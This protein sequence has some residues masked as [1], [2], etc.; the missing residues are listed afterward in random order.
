MIQ[1]Q[2]GRK[3]SVE[4]F[5]DVLNRSTLGERRPVN[6]RERMEQMLTA[7]QILV[8]AW[9]GEV[10]I[11]VSRALSDFS[12]CTYLADLAVDERYQH[13]GI[14]RTLLELTHEVAGL[15]TSLILLAAPKAVDYYPKIGM[16]RSEVCFLK[17]RIH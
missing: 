2:T 17:D 4:E 7:A 15:Q 3:L 6:D 16:K 9:E 14:G 12:F 1:Y 10:L 8:T 11:G 13:Q 5:I